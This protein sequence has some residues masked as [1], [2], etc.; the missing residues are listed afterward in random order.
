LARLPTSTTSPTL[1]L[2]PLTISHSSSQ[3]YEKVDFRPPWPDHRE[4]LISKS[5]MARGLIFFQFSKNDILNIFNFKQ[6]PNSLYFS[7]WSLKY[8]FFSV[9]DCFWGLL[10]P[11]IS[12]ILS[13][14]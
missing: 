10:R 5:T 4:G 8:A 12:I 9:F 13:D 2:H 7:K 14:K 3:Y 11:H 6:P 1:I